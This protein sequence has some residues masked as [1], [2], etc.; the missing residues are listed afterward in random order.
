MDKRVFDNYIIWK[1][2]TMADS[3]LNEELDAIEADEE[4]IN[5][6][7][8]K[9]LEFGT[10]GLRGEIGAGTNRMNIYTVAR[11][12][13]GYGRYLLK[14]NSNAKVAI[15]YDSRINSDKFAKTAA[16]CFAAMGIKVYIWKE[17]M[18]TP[19][20]S[21]TVRSLKCDGGIVITASHN[22]SRYNG[23]KVYGKDGCQITTG[24]AAQIYKYINEIDALNSMPD[25]NF[26]EGIK[27]GIIEYIEDDV[28]RNYIAEVKRTSLF[29]DN[30]N[31][32]IKVVYT[33]LH[34]TGLKPIKAV[35]K[36]MGYSNF[37]V[38]DKQAVADG[39]FPT[40]PYPNPEIGEVFNLGLEMADNNGAD[41]IIAT[42]PD[43][44][45]AGV[46]VKDRANFT[47]L[48]G[49]EIG[50]LLFD[51]ICKR[52]LELKNMPDNA[53]VITTIVSTDMINHI[54]RTYGVE[55][56]KVLTGFKFI[57]EQIGILE[58]KGEEERYIF[59]FE[60]SYGYL[61]GTY[62]RDKDAVNASLMVADMCEYYKN[63]GKTLADVLKELYEKYG[64]FLNT[65]H[66]I[67]FPGEYGMKSMEKIMETFRKRDPFKDFGFNVLEVRDYL[68]SVSRSFYEKAANISNIELPKSNVLTFVLENKISVTMRPSGTEPKLKLYLSINAKDKKEA[69]D[70]ERDVYTAIKEYIEK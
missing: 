69:Q 41:L 62:V 23:Y 27:Q 53:L 61:S 12:S 11:A 52:R 51:Y 9:E 65:L 55:V 58:N 3:L 10:G 4:A 63:Q 7:F 25:Y 68:E 31:K 43:C 18:P 67:E 39:N 5:D 45:R 48:S 46:V 40:C 56:I 49:N 34:G 26:D 32:N 30:V 66:S 22:P 36:E 47:L 50:I 2:F 38:V 29:N 20:L 28:F 37:Y 19:V 60:E 42:D 57:G 8:Y 6:R 70:L 33:P 1:N 15:A 13:T 24:S 54:A 16:L 17:I 64:F 35:M 44:D 21:F 14:N 59:G